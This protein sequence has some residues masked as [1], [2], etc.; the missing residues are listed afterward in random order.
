M[1]LQ[2]TTKNHGIHTTM[3]PGT[4][5]VT[6]SSQQYLRARESSYALHFCLL[7]PPPLHFFL[8]VFLSSFFFSLRRF[9]SLLTQPNKVVVFFLI[10]SSAR[11]FIVQNQEGVHLTLEKNPLPPLPVHPALP[12]A[13]ASPYLTI[14][15]N[16]QGPQTELRSC[17]KIDV[18][19][20][21]SPSLLSLMVSV[22]INH[23]ERRRRRRSRR[24]RRRRITDSR[25]KCCFT[26]TE[27]IGLLGTEAQDCHLDFHT[28]LLSTGHRLYNK[29]CVISSTTPL[30]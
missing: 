22:D 5:Q 28:Q 15:S 7:P 26:S 11:L 8:S 29:T 20:R 3:H 24:R 21:G 19:V 4:H 6:V 16:F 10:S 2:S 18:A 25:L 30:I 23:H 9:P 17:V 14:I 1:G 27:T 12:P 13:P